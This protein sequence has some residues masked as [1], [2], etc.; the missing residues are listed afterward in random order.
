MLKYDT[1]ITRASLVGLDF[2]RGFNWMEGTLASDGVIYC[3]PFNATRILA[4]NP[5]REYKE[6]LAVNMELYPQEFGHLFQ[7]NE[8]GIT[9]FQSASVQY[10]TPKVLQ[11]IIDNLPSGNEVFSTTGLY[12]FMVAAS[13]PN[14]VLSVI[15]HLLRQVPDLITIESRGLVEDDRSMNKRENIHICTVSAFNINP[16]ILCNA[17]CKALQFSN[18]FSPSVPIIYVPVHVISCSIVL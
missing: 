4:I 11:T 6:N 13:C 16:S 1:N 15:Y 14:G 9:N 10:G 12:P 3:L 8:E 5:F 17:R 18:V 2:G 7:E